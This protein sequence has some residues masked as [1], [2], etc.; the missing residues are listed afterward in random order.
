[1]KLILAALALCAFLLPSISA[2]DIAPP[3][4]TMPRVFN[5]K[6]FTGWVIPKDN[7]H[8]T[9]EDG[10]IVTRNDPRK[11]GSILWT[12]QKYTDFDI[13]LEFRMHAGGVVDSGVFLREEKFQIQIGISGSKKRDMTAS[14]YIPGKGYPKE[15]QGVAELL[16]PYNWNRLQATVRGATVNIWLNGTHVSTLTHPKPV[17]TGPIG[18]QLHAGKVMRTDFRNIKA[19]E[20]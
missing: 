1:M 17:K 11:K 13:D 20:R 10:M 14:V 5:G 8:W 2:K 9:T 3:P 12:E 15:A 16:K 7:I 6:D 19:A 18:L 4:D